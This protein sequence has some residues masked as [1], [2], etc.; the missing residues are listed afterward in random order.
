MFRFATM[1]A[2]VAAFSTVAQAQDAPR[3][4]LFG[5]YSYL[6]FDASA[7][8]NALNQAG[9]PGIGNRLSFN[10]WEAS[11]NV[12]FNRWLGAEGDLSGHY[13]GNCA[14]S[15]LE[16]VTGVTVSGV[17]CS[18]LSFM[19]GPRFTY[20]NG[21]FTAFAHGLFGGD[22]L[23]A[24]VST[25]SVPNLTVS[26][27]NTSFA[28][29]TGGGVDY[30]VTDRISVRLGQF[31]YF[32]TR[33]L[34]DIPGVP[35]QNNYRVSAGIVFA[36]GGTHE[37]GRVASTSSLGPTNRGTTRPSE[38]SEARTLGV[39][40]YA[41]DSGFTVTSVRDGSPAAQ[42]GIAPND[43]I[44]TIDGRTVHSSVEIE[45]VIAASQ[46]GTVSIS[47]LIGGAWLSQKDVRV[48]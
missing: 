33:H 1:L 28:F 12:N 21:R 17:T 45:A 19:G 31:D 46:N 23:S 10:G 39:F 11:A 20:R 15:L 9:L 41:T 8:N 34:N 30:A 38:T 14:G 37:V 25:G 44:T 43:I 6:N 32:L 26:V 40:G 42:A 2:L 47:Y 27:S 18:N 29:A 16:V 4:E 36:F 3:V 7:A 48:R 35:A 13:K 24:S 22:R 5:G